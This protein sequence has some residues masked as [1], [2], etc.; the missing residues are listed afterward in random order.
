LLQLGT[1]LARTHLDEFV[2][3]KQTDSALRLTSDVGSEP[4]EGFAVTSQGFLRVMKHVIAF[5]SSRCRVD[6]GHPVSI[7]RRRIWRRLLSDHFLDEEP[8]L[9]LRGAVLE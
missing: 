6:S 2:V 9:M 8:S 4:N 1:N 5:G 3:P 7:S